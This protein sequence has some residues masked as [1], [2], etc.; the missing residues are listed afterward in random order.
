MSKHT[1]WRVAAPT[2]PED[3]TATMRVVDERGRFVCGAASAYYGAEDCRAHAHLL[4]AAP[5]MLLALQEVHD[6]L[7]ISPVD[8]V[9]DDIFNAVE[10]A[11]AK[12]KGEDA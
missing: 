11:I 6:A 10:R 9:D 1:P 2:S 5:D 12:A 3:K 4:A 7:L 8:V